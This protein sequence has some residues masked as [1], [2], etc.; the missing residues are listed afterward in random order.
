MPERVA[1][2]STT[3]V[4]NTTVASRLSTAVTTDAT[5]NTSPSSRCGDPRLRRPTTA[6][7][8]SNTPSS[9]ARCASTSTAARN[10]T[11]GASVTSSAPASC[12][13]TSP[14]SDHQQR[15]RSRRRHL[16]QPTRPGHREC[17]HPDEEQHR[18][19]RA[20]QGIVDHRRRA[21]SPTIPA[22]P[23]P[24]TRRSDG[25]STRAGRG[26]SAGGERGPV[27]DPGPDRP[28]GLAAAD[29]GRGLVGA[30][31]RSTTWP[32][33]TRRSRWRSPTRP[34]SGPSWLS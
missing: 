20:H 22:E 32:G 11:V 29:P 13:D 31:P 24:G 33:S 4:S 1:V 16:R 27:P 3:G 23:A 14:S 25:G 5:A 6:P 21:R 26:G 2:A 28:G 18:H 17:Q 8:K 10:P 15:G 12:H 34:S 19:R 7:A 30:G 9:S